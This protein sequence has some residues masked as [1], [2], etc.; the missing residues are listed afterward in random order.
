MGAGVRQTHQS[1]HSGIV[2]PGGI[3]LGDRRHGA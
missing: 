1:N 2:L 3:C